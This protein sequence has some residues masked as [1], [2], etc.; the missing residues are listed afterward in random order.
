MCLKVSGSTNIECFNWK[1]P[2]HQ[3]Q[4]V[5]MLERLRPFDLNSVLTVL[6]R[7]VF[8][9]VYILSESTHVS[10]GEVSRDC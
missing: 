6:R 5:T 7:H 9:Y 2:A 8:A 4:S 3:L 10:M 1:W